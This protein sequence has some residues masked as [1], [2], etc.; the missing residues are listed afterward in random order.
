MLNKTIA[1]LVLISILPSLAFGEIAC[2]TCKVGDC[3]CTISECT[4]GMVDIFSGSSCT[5]DPDYEYIFSNGYFR[6][7]PQAAKNY[8]VKALCSD[9]ETQSDCSLVRVSLAAASTTTT[10]PSTTTTQPTSAGGSNFLT[11]A[12]V[13]LLIIAIIVAIYYYFFRKKTK[14]SY[15]ELYRKW[16][17]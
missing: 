7:T 8:Y 2:G 15:E 12:F 9:G 10:R 5:T 17:K 4:S 3:T 11:L 14:K 1:L 16:R 6:W 13:I